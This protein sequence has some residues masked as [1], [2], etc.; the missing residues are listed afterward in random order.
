M[1]KLRYY[2]ASY[3][4]VYTTIEWSCRKDEHGTIGES[5]THAL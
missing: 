3:N 5:S 1:Q 2:A 4:L